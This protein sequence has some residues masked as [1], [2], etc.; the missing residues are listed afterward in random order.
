M[1]SNKSTSDSPSPS[2]FTDGNGYVK[3]D[4]GLI[5]QWGKIP[6]VRFDEAHYEN[7]MFPIKF[8]HMCFSIVCSVQQQNKVSGVRV[9]YLISYDQSQFTILPGYHDVKLNADICWMAIGY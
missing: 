7:I 9:A 4:N 6:N 3:F 2:S 1:K 5:M 8:P